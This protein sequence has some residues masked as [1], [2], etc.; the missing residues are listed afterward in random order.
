MNAFILEIRLPHRLST[1]LL[2]SFTWPFPGIKEEGNT[3]TEPRAQGGK[4][5]SEGKLPH[6]AQSIFFFI[7]EYF[8]SQETLEGHTKVPLERVWILIGGL[9]L[10]TGFPLRVEGHA[11]GPTLQT[12][13]TRPT[14]SWA[15][16]GRGQPLWLRSQLHSWLLRVG[17]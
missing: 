5:F 2:H 10:Q 17:P 1:D 14:L 16:P 7:C 9:F 15:I 3:A 8:H 13:S 6:L 4:H 12:T 11:G